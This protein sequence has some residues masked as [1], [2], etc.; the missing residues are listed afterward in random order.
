MNIVRIRLQRLAIDLETLWLRLDNRR[1]RIKLWY[2][3]WSIERHRTLNERLLKEI[4]E[5]W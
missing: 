1:L 2:L 5:G 3:T 4:E